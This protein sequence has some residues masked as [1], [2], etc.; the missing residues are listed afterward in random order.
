MYLLEGK[1]KVFID[2]E[3]GFFEIEGGDLVVFFKGMKIIWDVFEVVK[4]YYSLEK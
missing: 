1:V 2:G 3:E 4:K